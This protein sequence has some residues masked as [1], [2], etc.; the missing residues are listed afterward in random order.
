MHFRVNGCLINLRGLADD[1]LDSLIA[2]TEARV[3]DVGEEL[4]SLRGEAI[5]RRSRIPNQSVSLD[6]LVHHNHD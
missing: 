3:M 5:R 1:E 6:E 2:Q 4:E